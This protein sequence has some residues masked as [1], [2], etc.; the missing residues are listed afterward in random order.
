MRN[1]GADEIAQAGEIGRQILAEVNTERAA[2][3]ICEHLKISTSLGRL[4]HPERILL[5]RYRQVFG[6]VA[7]DLQEHS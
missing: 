5:L 6:V 1:G 3:A 2:M 7:G 4:H